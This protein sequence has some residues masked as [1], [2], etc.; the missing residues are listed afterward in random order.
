MATRPPES[1]PRGVLPGE[2]PVGPVSAVGSNGEAAAG[3]GSWLGEVLNPKTEYQLPGL[4]LRERALPVR[5]ADLTRMLLREPGLSDGDR[6]KLAQFG[7]LL[8]ATFH[9]EFHDRLR[10]LKELYA[11]V[12]PDCEYLMVSGCSPPRTERSDDEFLGP[13]EATLRRANYRA[14]P[15][16]ALH[17]AISA[18]NEQGL[19]YVPDLG[20]FEHLRVYVRGYTRITRDCRSVQTRFRRRTVTLEAYQRLV[21]ALKFKPGIKLGPLVRSDVLYLRMF[22]DVPHVDMEMHL[23]EQG[24]RVRMRWIDKAQIASPLFVG[25]PSL[26]A[27]LLFA[28]FSPFA[29]GGLVLGPISAGVNSFFGFRRARQ[30][31]LYAMIYRLYYLSLANNASVLTRLIDSAEDEEYKEATLAYF[32]LWHNPPTSPPWNVRRLDDRIERFLRE[33]TGVSINFEVADALSKLIRLGLVRRDRSGDLH[34]IPIEQAL[35]T[36]DRRWDDRFRFS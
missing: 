31:H 26:A 12:D 1:D 13:F 30:K 34:A 33:K 36:L 29:L 3:E 6:E 11:P 16:H 9:A 7:R 28:T 2:G 25:I 10:E 27:K 18:P 17:Q 24:T 22:K 21:V 35:Q 14:L 20:L 19:T 5:Q 15:L 8:G 4:D 23:P 32:F